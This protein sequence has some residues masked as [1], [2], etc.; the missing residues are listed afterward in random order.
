MVLA[1]DASTNAVASSIE[2]GQRPWGIGVTA[3][4]KTLYTANGPSNDVSVIDLDTKKVPPRSQSAEGHGESQSSLV[5]SGSGPSEVCV[6]ISR[7]LTRLAFVVLLVAA[8]D[9]MAQTSSGASQGKAPSRIR[10]T[11]NVCDNGHGGRNGAIR[12]CR[13]TY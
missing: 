1:I 10:T 12:G 13:F 9:V 6:L 3:D 7:C 5:P 11:S 8:Q 4:G 2:A